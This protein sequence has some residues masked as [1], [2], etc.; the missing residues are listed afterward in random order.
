MGEDVAV[1]EVIGAG[2]T[3]SCSSDGTRMTRK[4]RSRPMAMRSSEMRTATKERDDVD[5]A[6][7][8]RSDVVD[9]A[10]G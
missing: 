4:A 10:V 5:A 1:G 2:M 7:E 6:V 8:G 3:R 9:I